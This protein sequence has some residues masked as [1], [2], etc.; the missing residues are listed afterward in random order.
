MSDLKV[1]SQAAVTAD[2]WTSLNQDHCLTVTLHYTKN[3]AV[4]GKVLK[5]KKKRRSCVGITG[6]HGSGTGNKQN[7]QAFWC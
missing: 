1:I 3:G 7:P 2:G 4:K 5:K 6:R